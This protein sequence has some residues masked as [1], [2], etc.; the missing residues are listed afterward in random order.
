MISSNDMQNLDIEGSFWTEDFPEDSVPGRLT[1]DPMSGAELVLLGELPT[2]Q[3]TSL[4]FDDQPTLRILGAASGKIVTLLD[5]M[6]S[7]AGGSIPG[8][9]KQKFFPSMV[10]TGAHIT[11][12]HSLAFN[13]VSLQFN[14]LLNWV[15]RSGIDPKGRLF[16]GSADDG[17]QV[18]YKPVK[19][20]T[21]ASEIG[22][23]SMAVRPSSSFSFNAIELSETAYLTVK[24]E[25]YKTLDE[26]S[27]IS[28][29]L[30]DLLTIGVHSP[31]LV[32]GASLSHSD[33][34]REVGGGKK[35][36][37]PIEVYSRGYVEEKP[38]DIHRFN[39]LFDYSAIGGVQGIARWLEMSSTYKSVVNSLLSHIYLPGLYEENRFSNIVIAAEGF[40][41]K[42][43]SQEGN[44]SLKANLEKLVSHVGDSFA[45]PANMSAWAK[46]VAS[47][48]NRL[49]HGDS[50]EGDDFDRI[51]WLGHSVYLLVVLCLL[52]ECGVNSSVLNSISE[53]QIFRRAT[54]A[55]QPSVH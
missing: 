2:T 39:M 36:K 26:I 21:F 55:L 31:A 20:D 53:F 28:T 24:F 40:A 9:I 22:E 34:I 23:L 35:Q 47:F 14:H 49:L 50:V 18:T 27:K 10:L 11:S 52:K 38:R 19:V 29:S 13:S 54:K 41:K 7:F 32:T 48:R 44:P 43:C 46:E 3:R 51:Y 45:P 25:E 1:F 16:R 42:K 5:C 4:S 15:G 6:A 30:K 8:I 12:A 17:F 37:V 33:F